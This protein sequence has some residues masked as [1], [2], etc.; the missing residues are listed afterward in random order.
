[1]SFRNSVSGDEARIEAR[2]SVIEA[3]KFSRIRD[4]E[5]R[6]SNDEPRYELRKRSPSIKLY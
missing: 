3:G 2:D 1:M 5:H 4:F 6:A